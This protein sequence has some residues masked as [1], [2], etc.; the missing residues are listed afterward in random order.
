MNTT[1]PVTL[2]S[3]RVQKLNLNNSALYKIKYEYVSFIFIYKCLKNL[4]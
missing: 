3:E 1:D 4:F 2:I